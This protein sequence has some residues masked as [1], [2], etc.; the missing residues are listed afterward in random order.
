MGGKLGKQMQEKSMT[1]HLQHHACGYL[2][3]KRSHKKQ[4]NRVAR[5]LKDMERHNIDIGYVRAYREFIWITISTQGVVPLP[6]NKK[7]TEYE[8]EIQFVYES[9]GKIRCQCLHQAAGIPHVDHKRSSHCI[10]ANSSMFPK[11]SSLYYGNFQYFFEHSPA[12]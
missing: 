6:E 1:V 10:M 7:N 9:D 11:T 2:L 12:G 5:I 8:M 3:V 4:Y